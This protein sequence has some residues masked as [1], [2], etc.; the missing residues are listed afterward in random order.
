[1]SRTILM[2]LVALMLAGCTNDKPRPEGFGGSIEAK[3]QELKRSSYSVRHFVKGN[4]VYV[5]VFVQGGNFGMPDKELAKGELYLTVSID[6]G[7]EVRY[8]TP[9]FSISG[10]KKGYHEINLSV[11]SYKQPGVIHRP[12]QWTVKVD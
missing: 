8:M 1:M 2:L 3:A 5:D 4:R 9:A 7:R 12:Y 10:L 6:G 11:Q